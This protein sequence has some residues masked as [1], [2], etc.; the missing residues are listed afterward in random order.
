MGK[1]LKPGQH[2]PDSHRGQLRHMAPGGSD[3]PTRNQGNVVSLFCF[4]YKET[5]ILGNFYL[6]SMHNNVHNETSTLGE[7]ASL[8]R[9]DLV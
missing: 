8:P 6:H 3:Y 2:G 1:N 4:N 5:N 9:L 7:N